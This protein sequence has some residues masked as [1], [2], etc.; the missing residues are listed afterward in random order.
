[1]LIEQVSLEH[2]LFHYMAGGRVFDDNSPVDLILHFDILEKR[3][4]D[5]MPKTCQMRIDREY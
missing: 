2:S 5:S 1:M 4:L 3:V